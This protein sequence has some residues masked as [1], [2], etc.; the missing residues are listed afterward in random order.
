[1]KFIQCYVL[2]MLALVSLV[3]GQGP[4]HWNTQALD[5]LNLALDRQTLNKNQ[6]KNVVFFLGDGMGVST[7][8]AARILKGQL[9]G[10]TG[11]EHVLSWENFP[12]QLCQREKNWSEEPERIKFSNVLEQLASFNLSRARAL[13]ARIGN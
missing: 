3:N 1:M 8:T 10:N 2:V 6:A 12:M 5:T 9:D 13:R 7:V 11:E 4:L